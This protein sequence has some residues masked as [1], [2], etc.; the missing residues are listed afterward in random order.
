M[1]DFEFFI[2]PFAIIL[3]AFTVYVVIKGRFLDI[4]VLIL[5]E[6]AHSIEQ[7]AKDRENPAYWIVQKFESTNK[8]FII[9]SSCKSVID[10][11]DAPINEN[12]YDYCPYCG[13]KVV[14]SYNE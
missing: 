2:F 14:G 3:S 4:I 10:C 1:S 12:E 13:K 7:E 9:C 6:T 11:T 5:Q 8:K